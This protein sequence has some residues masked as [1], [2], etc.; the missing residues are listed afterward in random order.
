MKPS[1][2]FKSMVNASEGKAEIIP[3]L[4]GYL[5]GGKLPDPFTVSVRGGTGD[6]PP[7]GWF[8]PSSHPLLEVRQLYYYLTDPGSWQ[9]E[10]FSYTI[11]MSALIGSMVHDVVETALQDLGYLIIPKGVCQACGLKQPSKCKEHGAADLGTKSRGH[12]DGILGVGG[13][14]RGFEFKTAMPLTLVKIRNND[15]EAFRA[16]WPYYYAQVQEYMRMTG[17]TSYK[18]IFWA[19]GNPWEMREFT[20]EADVTFQLQTERK[21][22]EARKAAD[23]GDLPI[24]CCAPRSVMSKNCPARACPIKDM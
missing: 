12:M 7:D 8:H 17:L 14:M 3:V 18:V 2:R 10:P 24:P 22:L 11:K 19:M 15:I 21:Y 9:P 1:S 20:I 16:K 13:V 23:D 4:Y 5:E 6:R